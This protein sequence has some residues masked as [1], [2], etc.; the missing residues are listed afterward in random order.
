MSNSIIKI[1]PSTNHIGAEIQAVSLPAKLYPKILR[2]INQALL[3]YKV[4]FFDGQQHLDN[5]QQEKFSHLFVKPI[6]HPTVPAAENSNF[7]FKLD[8]KHSGR[9]D[10]WYTYI[11]FVKAYPKLTTLCAVI[12]PEICRD[13]TWAN[14]ETAYEEPPKTLKKLVNQLHAIHTNASLQNIKSYQ[15]IFTSSV[16]EAEHPLVRIHPK[17]GRKG[18]ILGDFFKRFIVL[19]TSKDS[20]KLFEIFQDKI[21]KHENTVHWKWQKDHVGIGDNRAI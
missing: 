9:V 2:E 6:S 8:S 7:I 5:N 19:L 18:L 3:T 15:T 16:Y 10:V 13:T 14:T 11:T 12:F 21:T 1:I 4:I 17:T 20:N